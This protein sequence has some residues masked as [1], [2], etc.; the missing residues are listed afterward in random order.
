MTKSTLI[1]QLGAVAVMAVASAYSFQA[2]AIDLN[3]KYEPR[4][5]T[6]SERLQNFRPPPPAPRQ[7]TVL[8]RAARAY[9][10]A[11]VRPTVDPNTR[12]PMIQY[13]KK[14]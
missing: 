2:A 9:D 11:P 7:D 3:P 1:V 10:N 14:W 12:T 13:N 8:D 6:D 4:P 5:Q